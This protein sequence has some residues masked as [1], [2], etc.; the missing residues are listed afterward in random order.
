[1]VPLRSTVKSFVTS[2]ETRKRVLHRYEEPTRGGRTGAGT[3]YLR[4]VPRM[5][6]APGAAVAAP[7]L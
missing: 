1:M 4:N 7:L 3:T 6:A 5:V 2:L